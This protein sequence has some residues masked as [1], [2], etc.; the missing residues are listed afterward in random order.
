MKQKLLLL[1]TLLVC[2]VSGAWADTVI[3][4]IDFSEAEWSGVTFTQG[5]SD[6]P[7]TKN[8][9][10]FNAK[11]DTYNF[12]ISDGVLTFPGTNMGSGNYA[13]GFPVTGI[14]GGVVYVKVYNGSSY[15]AFRYSIKDG[16]TEFNIS[17]CGNGASLYSGFVTK[18]DLANT[19]AYIYIG[20][21]GAS[22]QT[23]TKIEVLTPELEDLSTSSFYQLYKQSSTTVSLSTLINDA[24]LPSYLMMD[25]SAT[26]YSTGNSSE[27]TS[28]HNFSVIDDT[29]RYYR[30]KGSST[31]R[32]IIGGLSHV[33]TIHLYG[34][35]NTT[36]TRNIIT[37]VKKLSGD[38]TA[39]TV[40]NVE[41]ENS[42]QTVKEY[43]I[44]L[45]SRDGYNANTYYLYTIT[46]SNAFE[47][48]GLYIETTSSCTSVDAP[49]G[50]SC[51]AHTK[52]SLT[53]GWT[54]AANADEYTA[55]LYSDSGC[56][57]EVTTT[58]NIDGTSVKFSD[59]SANV[60]YY[61]KVQSNGDGSTYCAEGNVTDAASGTTDSKDYTLTVLSNDNNYGTATA[62]AVSLDASETTEITAAAEPGYKFRS[63]A[64]SGTGALLSSTTTNPTTLTMGT[65]NAT[66]TATFSAL[67][68][69]TI[70]YNK[71]AN[72]SGSA[73]A[74][75]V[76]TED[77][78]FTLSSSTYT[79]DGH[80]QTGWATSDG[81]DK[82]YDLGGTYT[83]NADLDLYP[84]WVEQ[85]TITY[86]NNGGMGSMIAT[87]GAGEVTLKASGF[88][89]PGHSFLGWATSDD[90][91]DAGIVEYA[92]QDTYTLSANVTLYAVWGENYCVMKVA[93]SGDAITSGDVVSVQSGAFGGTMI[94]ESTGA[95]LF[96]V[97]NGITSPAGYNST[98][99]VTLNDFMKPGT[100]I[101]LTLHNIY[102]AGYERGYKLV[103]S[104]GTDISTMSYTTA[105]AA[106]FLYTVTAEDALNG[107]NSFK[108]V[109]VNT[110]GI[111]IKSLT[112]TDCQPG[113]VITASGWSTYSSNKKLDL[114]TISGG[115]AYVAVADEG[116]RVRMKPCTDIV[117]AE[118]GLMIK[119]TAD[120]TF[121]I[122]TT[123]SDATL[124]MSN[125]MEGLP[126][127]GT[128]AYGDYNYVFGWPTASKTP[129]NDCGFYYVDSSAAKL[130]IGKAYLHVESAPS[131]RL[132]LFI[133]DDD[134]TTG[135]DDTL[136]GQTAN[137]KLVYDLQGRKVAKPTKG[138]YI[139]DG[140]KVVIK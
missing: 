60:T 80:V 139:V 28:P 61:C 2:M 34:N 82:A 10:T 20:R 72:G 70:T 76:K 98:L 116:T 97:S 138:M 96:Y 8:G 17:D 108:L 83:G 16:G 23:I 46:F 88:V 94:V 124:S 11:S 100:V 57:S 36:Q 68:T 85:F 111:T 130:G 35:G 75:G 104:N 129:A 119:G 24:N 115:T 73:I 32:I 112:V 126:N 38:G 78:D 127:G 86:D 33:K 92:D 59:L 110:N 118:T 44:D 79:Y 12:S 53:F 6:D 1:L 77:A 67:E 49:T 40:P 103:S 65:A 99:T 51:T 128:V 105:N 41:F 58:S 84:Y 43:S 107:T 4:T 113:G 54:A 3:K 27:V 29:K 140:K 18:M 125:L 52:N 120:A 101:L 7:E 122:N 95:N 56:T 15:Q 87:T 48:W 117:A 121:T 63:W 90:N 50:L 71:G 137:G 62:V 114:S 19:T 136:N 47:L 123:T 133:D 14:V 64:V 21:V 131:A 109:K 74:D 135:I 26:N 30:L 93:T 134:M 102:S 45:A 42:Y 22:Y 39:M 132:S 66:V 9:V 31:S 81:G 13:L 55:T 91:A 37:T 25:V 5:A 89:K 69:Y 106:Q